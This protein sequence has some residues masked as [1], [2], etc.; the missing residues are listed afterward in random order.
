MALNDEFIYVFG[1]YRNVGV[2]V[3]MTINKLSIERLHCALFLLIDARPQT[4]KTFSPWAQLI[5]NMPFT[6]RTTFTT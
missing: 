5:E 3:C 1:K 6:R 4:R 2:Y